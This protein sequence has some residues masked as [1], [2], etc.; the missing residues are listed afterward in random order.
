MFGGF[1]FINV[2]WGE[3]YTK[4]FLD[5]CLPSQLSPRNLKSFEDVDNSVYKIYTTPNDAK[6]ITNHPVYLAMS[7]IIKT[8][9]KIFN[10]SEYC[11][12]NYKH[13]AMNYCHQHAILEANQNDCALVF[14]SP[15]TIW[16]DGSFQTLL[17][18]ANQGKRTVMIGAY[19]TVKETIVPSFL[20]LF[21]PNN[22]TCISISCRELVKLF[23]EHL[24]PTT[25][26]LFWG[27]LGSRTI[28]P[29]VVLWPVGNQGI[30]AKHFHIHPLMVNPVKKDI[31]PT[32]TIDG[33]YISLAC[34]NQDEIY[35]VQDSDEIYACELS[36]GNIFAEHIL[37]SES[38]DVTKIAEWMKSATDSFHQYCF[39]KYT[40]K[41]HTDDFSEDWQKAEK[42]INHVAEQIYTVFRSS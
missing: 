32:P 23:L 8:K 38:T 42:K 3:S 7:K 27:T 16:G 6:I 25:K 11:L 26:S 37:P 15:D 21:N 9:I 33:E 18:L 41:I 10:L 13:K 19:R 40:L 12:K 5:V 22:D 31:L 20:E 35:V 4:L 2:V 39:Q 14:L 28:W 24:H 17:N 36:S 30:L 29:S 1:H 34:P